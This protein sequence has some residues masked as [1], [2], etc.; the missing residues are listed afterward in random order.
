MGVIRALMENPS[1]ISLQLIPKAI[2]GLFA[3][4]C[5]NAYIVGLNQIYDVDIDK[6]NKPNLPIAA[7]LLSKMNAWKIVVF[8]AIT[9]MV[10]ISYT[11]TNE[12]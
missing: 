2:I 1:K 12:F 10:D 7:N 3:L 9:G 8:C 4:L 11:Y 5:G 6:I